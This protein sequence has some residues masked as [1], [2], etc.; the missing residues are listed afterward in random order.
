MKRMNKKIKVLHVLKSSVY[1]GAE[2]VV[3]TIM[4][5]LAEQFDFAYLATK[6]EIEAVLK[7]EQLSYYLLKKYTRK[8]IGKVIREF[9]PDIV[10]AHDFTATVFCSS[11]RKDFYLISHLH[12]DPPWVKHWNLKTILYACCDRKINKLL[13]VSQ[14]MIQAMVFT[15][16]LKI[17]PSKIFVIKNPLDICR[18]K[19]GAEVEG[20]DCS[21]HDVVFIGRFVEQKDPQRFI[22]IISKV[23]RAGLVDI[24]CIMLG[25]GTLFDACG[26]LIK[27]LELDANIQMAGFQQN[28]YRYI[29][30]SKILCMTS[31]WEGFGLVLAEAN[32]LGVPALSTKTS[33]ACEV[34][35][36]DAWEI[37][38]TDSEFVEKMTKLLTKDME[39]QNIQKVVQK[40]SEG[41]DNLEDYMERI[42]LIYEGME[43]Q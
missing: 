20:S 28:P 10:H 15:K 23:K 40:R 31:R 35:G 2:N 21:G 19:S 8:A 30:N 39:Y 26:Y 7:K 25:E 14:D 38:T 34:L 43:V 27:E 13:V 29:K 41:F 16:D 37:C 4:K 36:R 9:E 1:S 12:Y 3:I 42:A 32:V 17:Q 33:G 11:L 5:H 24:N 22:R 6:G 18:I